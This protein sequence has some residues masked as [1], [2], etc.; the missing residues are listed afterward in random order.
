MRYFRTPV[1]LLATF[2]GLCGLSFDRAAADD[3]LLRGAELWEEL[4]DIHRRGVDAR[5]SEV[6]KHGNFDTSV[7]L[8]YGGG[9]RFLAVN[10]VGPGAARGVP[11]N[12]GGPRS[13]DKGLANTKNVHLHSTTYSGDTARSSTGW[14][15]GDQ[16]THVHP[17]S[18]SARSGTVASG[19]V[20]WMKCFKGTLLS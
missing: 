20:G 14:M 1:T 19:C 7:N 2:I 11:R 3:V 8:G 6:V 17:W 4:E 12:K 15:C 13:N 9:V 10:V 18:T 16:H 5:I